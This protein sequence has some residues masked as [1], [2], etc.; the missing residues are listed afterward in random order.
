MFHPLMSLFVAVLFFVLTPGVLLSI[1]K[2]GSLVKKAAV[3]AV[4]FAL[5]YHFSHKAVLNFFYGI[6][7][8]ATQK[9]VPKPPPKPAPK[10]APRPAPRAAPKP[11]AKAA[12]TPAPISNAPV[13]T[14]NSVNS[15]QNTY[16][17]LDARNAAIQ[18]LFF[19]DANTNY[20]I[21]SFPNYIPMTPEKAKE[22][23]QKM[24][25]IKPLFS[26]DEC[27]STYVTCSPQNSS[28]SFYDPEY[29]KEL[30][31]VSMQQ[32]GTNWKE[33][34]NVFYF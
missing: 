8:F 18:A 11:A 15:V 5:V 17:D 25:T 27:S 20:M 4:V 23:V 14:I 33:S 10:P 26:P 30:C 22:V 3:H 12:L 28:R 7:G 19:P 6:E 1:P 2:K 24:S 32:C 16:D 31:S 29:I 9:P 21:P 34:G 13:S